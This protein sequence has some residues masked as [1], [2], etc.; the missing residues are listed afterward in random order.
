MICAKCGTLN[1]DNDKF[2]A[3][4]GARMSAP[5]YPSAP[6]AMAPQTAQIGSVICSK[7]GTQNS[8]KDK[9]CA[10]CGA[11][12]VAAQTAPIPVPVAPPVATGIQVVC[13]K[14]GVNN[15]PVD[16]FCA[17]CG[18]SLDPSAPKATS[19]AVSGESV[20]LE[21]SGVNGKIG[22]FQD[23]IQIQ[24]NVK[25]LELNKIAGVII[26]PAGALTNGYIHFELIGAEESKIENLETDQYEYTILF[27][28]QQQKTFEEIKQ[29][30][31][32]TKSPIA[33]PSGSG[34]ADL[35]KLAELKAKGIITEEEF[36]AKKK[37]IL[38][39]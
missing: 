25:Y 8:G 9:F 4:C 33:P 5:A 13:P 24:H 38:G 28:K 16:K 30:I 32:E 11:R 17:K 10:K 26:K 2:C 6:P 31:D 27:N 36:T 29:A 12:L 39:L 21:A 14:C 22:L 20:V 15:S 23:K 3:K 35:E 19:A 37:Q 7:C 1:A 18:S 34:I